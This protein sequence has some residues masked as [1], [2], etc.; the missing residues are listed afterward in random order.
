MS[1]VITYTAFGEPEV[2]TVTDIPTPLPGP[3]ELGVRIE[4]AGVNP[5]DLKLRSG[6]RASG[7]I[8]E[9]RRVG[10]DG[11]GVVTA[12]G[13]GVEGF[14][15]GDTVVLFGAAGLYATDVV[16]T[17]GQAAK[18]PPQVSASEGAALGIPAGTA[19]QTLRSL[20]V[21]PGD[22]LLVHG[23]S[24]AV[25]QAVIQFAVLWGATVLATTSDRRADR[26]R[27]LGATPISYA[28]GLEGRVRAAAPQGVTAAID[29]AG[30]DEAL[31]TSL[32]LVADRDRIATLVRGKDAADLGIRAFMGGSPVPL[33]AQE[34]AWR[35][36]AI[37]VTLAL[38]AAGRF[39]VELGAQ[40]PLADAAAAH[41]LVADGIDGKVV[42]IP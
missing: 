29:I 3:G 8:V 7:D 28:P 36:E 10:G 1:T 42:L 5:L 23:G 21:G 34:K 12:V 6:A 40:V 31:E 9:P 11:A 17:P 19:Y 13:D 41:H 15:V 38:L 18:R 20:A 25:G 37:P 39:T 27:S 24:G 22:T 32:T 35:A 33:S 16:V 4:A 30:T 14:R 26:V 2:L